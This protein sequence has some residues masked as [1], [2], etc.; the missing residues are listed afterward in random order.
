[1]FMS[2][3]D[4][5][6]SHIDNPIGARVLAE[7]EKKNIQP[8]LEELE[9]SIKDDKI[10]NV[11]LSGSYGTGKSS[12]IKTFIN[13][14]YLSK[15]KNNYAIISIGSFLMYDTKKKQD[16]KNQEEVESNNKP[17]DNSSD[18]KDN[19]YK[20][21]LSDQVINLDEL[22]VVD[23]IEESILKQLIHKNDCKEM[24]ESS[25]KRLNNTSSR[26]I[27][28]VFT[29]LILINLLIFIVFN[30]FDIVYD[31]VSNYY[32]SIVVL[33]AINGFISPFYFLYYCFLLGVF[34]FLVYKFLN[35]I[36]TNNFIKSFKTDAASLEFK[37][38]ED[39]PFNKKL[40]E[41]LYVIIQNKIEALFFEDIDRFGDDIVLMVIEELKELNTIINSSKEIK[42]NVTFIYAFKDDIFKDYTDRSKFYDYIISV[43]PLS[44]SSN[45]VYLLYGLLEGEKIDL[46]LIELLSNHLTDYRTMINIINDYKMFKSV[47]DIT[48]EEKNYLF[49]V[50]IYKNVEISEYNRLNMGNNELDKGIRIVNDEIE[51]Y[52]EKL[53]EIT[54][55]C[56]LIVNEEGEIV[57]NKKDFMYFLI[58]TIFVMSD[59]KKLIENENDGEI[60]IPDLDVLLRA[61]VYGSS[62]YKLKEDSIEVISKIK[63]LLPLTYNYNFYELFVSCSKAFNILVKRPKPLNSELNHIFSDLKGNFSDLVFDLILSGYLNKN[64]LDYISLP[65]ENNFLTKNDYKYIS[66]V[67]HGFDASCI[68][69]DNPESVIKLITE[70]K[71]NNLRNFSLFDYFFS[72]HKDKRVN[73]LFYNSLLEFKELNDKKLKFLIDYINGSIYAD[74]LIKIL[75]EKYSL[76]TSLERYCAFDKYNRNFVDLILG[77]I[78]EID[79]IDIKKGNSDFFANYINDNSNIMIKLNTNKKVVIDRLK[80]FKIRFKNVTDLDEVL[81]NII[82]DN[83]LYAFT[84]ENIKAYNVNFK[85]LKSDFIVYLLSDLEDFYNEFYSKNRNF[86]LN[87]EILTKLILGSNLKAKNKRVIADR[88][89]CD[90]MFEEADENLLLNSTTKVNWANVVNEYKED[91]SNKNIKKLVRFIIDNRAKLFDITTNIKVITD[92]KFIITLIKSMLEE[93]MLKEIERYI[94]AL[95][96]EKGFLISGLSYINIKDNYNT[97]VITFMIDN[98]LVK[99]TEENAKKILN[100]DQISDMY[101]NYFFSNASIYNGYKKC[102][103]I[104]Q[105]DINFLIYFLNGKRFDRRKEALMHLS[106]SSIDLKKCYGALFKED[107]QKVFTVS[108]YIKLI[109]TNEDMF[110]VEKVGNKYKV[111]IKK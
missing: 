1:M 81:K 52:C 77:K 23:K 45:S 90:Y 27:T 9:K 12:I 10:C 26:L 100:Y 22:L 88:E 58:N 70:S 18:V 5:T 46:E 85:D 53:D 59:N 61:I 57:E 25:I 49:A 62:E 71:Y 106:L 75:V 78:L 28:I 91:N 92:K 32:D 110:T 38:V 41:I 51:K 8:Y 66:R 105:N 50:M 84:F 83:R 47:L 86:K 11:A 44:T 74:N 24:P 29:L 17:I 14:Y 82:Y 6:N 73:S 55:D 19:R 31:L 96:S 67:H 68:I 72:L 103:K 48:E 30:K 64:Y 7:E 43:M 102:F 101:K 93:N 79:D 65:V 89:N 87:N 108:Q 98:Y 33:K 20:K 42:H 39:L 69:I 4:N 13:D 107:E 97:D 34:L 37:G 60:D 95:N 111:T 35:K 15:S 56:M 63:K 94:S 104:I 3:K 40:F 80:M 36:Y 99:Y 76:M 21:S 109:Q 54:E 16:I 2:K